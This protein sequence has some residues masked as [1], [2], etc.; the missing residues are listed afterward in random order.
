MNNKKLTIISVTY[1][2]ENFIREALDGFVMQKTN[3]LFEVIVAD[4]ASVDKTPEIIREYVEKYPEIIK[5]IF[6]EKNIGPG[7]NFI[8]ALM[9]IETPYVAECEGDDYWTDPLKLQKQVDFLDANPDCSICFHPV[10]VKFETNPKLNHIFPSGLSFQNSQNKLTINDLVKR[11]FIQTNSVMYR[12]RFHEDNLKE[13]YPIDMLPGDHYLHLLHAEKGDIGFINEIMGIYRRHPDGTWWQTSQNFYEHHKKNGFKELKFFVYI[14]KHFNYKYTDIFTKNAT[15]IAKKMI[16]AFNDEGNFVQLERMKNEYNKYYNFGMKLL[17]LENT[18]ASLSSKIHELESGKD[19]FIESIKDKKICL[20]GAGAFLGEVLEYCNTSNL[21]IV[22]F[23]D[24]NKNKAN[25]DIDGYKIFH[26]DDIVTLKPDVIIISVK[27][28][29]P[30]Y[31][32]L[33]AYLFENNLNIPLVPNFFEQIR[34]KALLNLNKEENEKII[35]KIVK[36]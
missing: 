32:E 36:I 13:L 33:L 3:F 6:R 25:Q 20:Y 27:N 10:E 35:S 12:W 1:N 22:G 18:T 24:G 29:E 11:N 21:N 14:D 26:K 8:D 30:C 19:N 5:P 31:F 34:Y 23:I 9:R 28:W 4:D 17:K 16:L 7:E 15:E 2:H